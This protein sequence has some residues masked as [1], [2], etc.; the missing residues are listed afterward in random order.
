MNPADAPDYPSYMMLDGE[1]EAE[2][3]WIARGCPA[4]VR[5]TDE[6][7]AVMREAYARRSAEKASATGRVDTEA[8]EKVADLH[9]ATLERT[10]RTT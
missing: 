8:A 5:S 7:R 4:P 9:R 3:E 2:D 1:Q 10:R 6:Q